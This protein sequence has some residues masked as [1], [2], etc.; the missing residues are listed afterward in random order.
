VMLVDN[1]NEE[2]N[3]QILAR[4]KRP[5]TLSWWNKCFASARMTV[6]NALPPTD[7]EAFYHDQS[8]K[9]PEDEYFLLEWEHG[10]EEL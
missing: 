3:H 6:Q 7:L 9:F 5:Q 2:P 4:A 10:A 1:V 8:Q